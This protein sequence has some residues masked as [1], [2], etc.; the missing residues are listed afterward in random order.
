VLHDPILV[1][2]GKLSTQCEYFLF[3]SSETYRLIIAALIGLGCLIGGLVHTFYISKKVLAKY[4]LLGGMMGSVV[5]SLVLLILSDG[6]RGNDF[7]RFMFPAQVLGA[8]FMW[9]VDASSFCAEQTLIRVFWGTSITFQICNVLIIQSVPA[10]YSGV[11]SSVFQMCT[12]TGKRTSS[13]LYVPISLT[14]SPFRYR[15]R[16]RCSSCAVYRPGERYRG[17]A[18]ASVW[19]LFLDRLPCRG[20]GARGKVRAALGTN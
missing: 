17:L 16:F 1:V 8:F 14:R 5:P 3:P 15:D 19:V 6:G 18:C 12:Q 4:R 11:G 13:S 7:W 10:E 9:Y 2:A 20:N